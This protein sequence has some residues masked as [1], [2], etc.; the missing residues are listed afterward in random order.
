MHFG[1]ICAGG[2]WC[3]GQ[4][5]RDRR[6]RG[7]INGAA[8]ARERGQRRGRAG[9]LQC[10]PTML[11]VS[12]QCRFDAAPAARPVRQLG[13]RALWRSWTL[14][15]SVRTPHVSRGI[16][17]FRDEDLEPVHWAG[18]DPRQ[19]LAEQHQRQRVRESAV[20]NGARGFA[21]AVAIM[22]EALSQCL[23]EA[24]PA[25]E[26]GWAAR[27]RELSGFSRASTFRCRSS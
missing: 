8:G 23:F 25:G 16:R 17:A 1:Q 21:D 13:A 7:G 20:A 18:T 5:R 4:E 27:G 12:S 15:Y 10:R 19:A 6:C 24:A 22:L 2:R 9:G 26:A 11:E 3:A 14:P